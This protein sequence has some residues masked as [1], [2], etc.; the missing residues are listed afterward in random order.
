MTT[1]IATKNSQHAIFGAQALG[2]SLLI[3]ASAHI[4]VPFWPV[5]MT[6]QTFAVLAIAGVSGARLGVAAMVAYLVEGALGLPVFASG[7][8]LQVLAGP[9]AGYLVGMLAAMLIVGSARG[10]V[11]R[12]GAMVVATVVIYAAGAAWLSQFVGVERAIAAGVVPFLLGDVVKAAL[13]WAFSAVMPR[14]TV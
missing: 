7:A 10:H 4:S 5:P 3:A 11:Q 1:A 2:L 13:A 12:A 14:H 8:G 9:T 6:L